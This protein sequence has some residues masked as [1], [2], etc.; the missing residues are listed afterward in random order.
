MSEN[1]KTVLI[2]S[3][4]AITTLVGSAGRDVSRKQISLEASREQLR[5]DDVRRQ[6]ETEQ[7]VYV[8]M[9]QTADAYLGTINRVALR[10][11]P[12]TVLARELD[13]AN[14]PA[15]NA[16]DE[17]DIIGSSR[18]RSRFVDELDPWITAT[19]LPGLALPIQLSARSVVWE[20]RHK[21]VFHFRY[22]AP[23]ATGETINN[24]KYD[25]NPFLAFAARSTS[26]FPFA[27]EP[28]PSCDAG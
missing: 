12:P 5:H 17:V 6:R 10:N 28:M 21:N 8:K 20:R 3:T 23:L 24:F 27:F 14:D 26:S 1:V 13:R 19:D 15:A 16:A 4:A 9:M 2:A 11:A 7:R 18:T 22:A 25:D